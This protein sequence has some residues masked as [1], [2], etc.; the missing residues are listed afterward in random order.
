M[1][2]VHLHFLFD[3]LF[4]NKTSQSGSQGDIEA[5]HQNRLGDGLGQVQTTIAE[6]QRLAR[7][8]HAM[9]NPVAI[10]H[11]PGQ[12]FLL[13][14]HHADN[15]WDG[16]VTWL[17]RDHRLALIGP[18]LP[19]LWFIIFYFYCTVA[20]IVISVITNPWYT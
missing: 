19:Y 12:L 17:A 4:G 10:T 7:A 14:V 2:V 1:E 20:T 16:A 8:G 15:V 5:Q 18:A 9:D 13:Q 6:D 11:A 3:A